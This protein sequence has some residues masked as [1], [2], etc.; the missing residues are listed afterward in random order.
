MMLLFTACSDDEG[1]VII[2]P[3]DDISPAAITSMTVDNQT[4]SSAVLS[5]TSVGDDN[6]IGRASEYDIRYSTAML[7]ES[8]F[9]NAVRVA[10]G[11]TPKVIG[12]DETFTVTGLQAETKYYFA[13]KVAD[14]EPNWSEISN[15]DSIFTN[16]AGDWTIFNTSNSGLLSDVIFDIAFL[17]SNIYFGTSE[18]LAHFDGSEWN[19]YTHDENNSNS[20]IGNDLRNI[21]VGSLGNIWLGTQGDGISLFDGANFTNFDI[22]STGGDLATNAIRAIA[23][24]ANNI[25]WIGTKGH[26]LFKFES[27]DWTQYN[28]SNSGIANNSISS[29]KVDNNNN[30]WIGYSFGIDNSGASKF[31]GTIFTNYNSTNGFPSNAVWAIDID[32]QGNIWFGTNGGVVVF[33]GGIT[34]LLYS[35]NTSDINDNIVIS[36]EVSGSVKWIG[37]Q[38]GLNRFDGTNWKLITTANSQLPGSYINVLAKNSFGI[39]MIGT[40]NGAAIYSNY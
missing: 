2:D 11:M 3:G 37:T 19:V 27:G 14:E 40:N 23:I 9:G 28:T 16:V 21:S 6:F 38:Y 17:N 32:N 1:N 7:T 4:G 18:G 35:T 12:Y 34:W 20:I 13:I 24:D 22:T 31:D 10:T 8:N 39:L 30:L 29:L 25:T 36:L 33:D 26:G 15:I 5:W